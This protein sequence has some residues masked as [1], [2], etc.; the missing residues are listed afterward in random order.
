MGKQKKKS[1]K[2]TL[3]IVAFIILNIAVIVATAVNE[4]GNSTNAAQLSEVQLNV[5][6]R[7]LRA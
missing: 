6:G 7:P 1:W 4:F 3:A 2:K 5:Q